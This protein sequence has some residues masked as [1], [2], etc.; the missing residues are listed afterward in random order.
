MEDG[1]WQLALLLLLA[2]AVGA[3]L[4]ILFMLASA[5][6]ELRRRIRDSGPKIEQ[7][8]ERALAVSERLER[9]TRGLEEKEQAVSE[10]LT[11]GRE[12]AQSIEGV[13]RSLR[14]A[15]AV[16]NSVGPAVATFVAAMR[17]DGNRAPQAGGPTA[18]E[19]AEA[20]SPAAKT[21]ENKR[22]GGGS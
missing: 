13:K 20:P 11:A 3:L 7:V 19:A 15:Q 1:S 6:R 10:M 22:A 17:D 14:I 16:G 2:L 8:L 5:V 21:T 9:N 4:P 18:E 12:L